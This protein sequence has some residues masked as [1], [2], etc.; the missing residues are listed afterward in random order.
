MRT[1]FTYAK[2]YI[3][4]A[5]LSSAFMIAEVALDLIQP[6]MMARIVNEGILGLGGSGHPDI[7]LVI[8]VGI[9]MI[10]LVLLGSITG[11]LSAVF[12]N[13]AAQNTG[14]D[15]RKDCFARIM[16]FSFSEVDHF[17]TGSLITRTTG[18]VDQVQHL[19][20]QM[21]RSVVRCGMFFV[22]GTYALVSLNLSFSVILVV[23]LPLILADIIFVVW[24]TNPL[25]NLF[26]KKMDSLNNVI[27]EDING[28]RVVK[29]FVQEKR[30]NARFDDTQDD[31]LQTQFKV[32][33]LMTFLRPVMNI[34]LNL[35]IVAIIL[36]GGIQVREGAI[37]PGTVMAAIT[38]ISQILN[39]MMLLAMIFQTISRGV[40]SAG[41]LSEI[42][43]AKPELEE[44]V[45]KKTEHL[46]GRSVGE[47]VFD[48]VSF[49]Y[50]GQSQEILHDINLRIA[51]G[52]TVAI[53]GATGCGKT[54]LINLIPRFYDVTAGTVKV[55]RIDVRRYN[56][57]TL[58]NAVTV[59]LQKSEL[60]AVTIKENIAL[61]NPEAQDEEIR[62]A[63]RCAQADSFI[64]EQP[65]G[66]DTIVAQGGM[67]LSGGQRQRVAIAR[68]LLR[69]SPILILDDST[70]ALD[71]K[72]EAALYQALRESYRNITKIMIVQRIASARQADKIIVLDK[73]TIDANTVVS[74]LIK[75]MEEYA[76]YGFS[77]MEEKLRE[78]KGYF[79]SNR[80]FL[81]IFLQLTDKSQNDIEVPEE[82]EEL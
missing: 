82:P 58:R 81:D 7:S 3:V 8:S 24:K 66:Y 41:R 11:I 56:K 10:L 79:F 75:T 27:Q 26:Q 15:L 65:D 67:S 48:H 18:D 49:H 77:V 34:V 39:G 22:G 60:F 47:I 68:A 1:I 35:A 12:V 23:A 54:S 9:R 44:G 38:Y 59:C 32:T 28:I 31:L 64:N 78:D 16:H 55:G 42:L 14:N 2:K 46:T 36:V 72:T 51:S 53:V 37:M 4:L 21:V 17:S 40:V 57:A 30:E 74:A 62:E 25:F 76:N 43:N 29:S 63:A 45:L 70:S 73:G 6:R 52:E 50:P 80:A 61:G 5:M 13:L 71:L 33:M 20:S 69:K 19:I